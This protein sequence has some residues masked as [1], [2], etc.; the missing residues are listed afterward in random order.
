MTISLF[1][2]RHHLEYS[3]WANQRLLKAVQELTPEE[4]NRDFHTA[5]HSV[6]GTLAHLLASEIIWLARLEGGPPAPIA[7]TIQ[8]P[9][10]ADLIE[11]WAG[12]GERWRKWIGS[13]SD[14]DGDRIVAY[15]DLRGNR[16]SQPL[17]QLVLHVVNH[18]SHHRG[19]VAGF[20]RSMGKA[21]P[22]VDFI[23]FVRH[24]PLSSGAGN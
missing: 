9:Q 3:I 1:A 4:L 19:Q 24:N 16:W 20:L 12:V 5:D 8:E 2:L 18:S 22:S 10:L 15:A 21:P 11:Q 17:W 23:A 14:A 7:R 6:V 13:L